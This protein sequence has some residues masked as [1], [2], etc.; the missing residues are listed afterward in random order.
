MKGQTLSIHQFHDSVAPGDAITQQLLF[1]QSSLKAVGITG[2]IFSRNI[3]GAL[4]EKVLPFRKENVWDCDVMLVHFSMGL[5]KPEEILKLEIPKALVYHNITPPEFFAHDSFLK[6]LAANG[7]KQLARHA[8]DFIANFSDS[9]FNRRELEKLGYRNGRLLPLFDLDRSVPDSS[10]RKA[11]PFHLLFVGRLAP[12]K[13]QALLIK[14]FYHL[15]SELP[16]DS[17]LYLVGTGDPI[18]THYLRLLIVQ[19]GLEEHVVLPGKVQPRELKRFY[20]TAGAFISASHH[21][22]F[23][24]PLVESMQAGL[25]VFYLPKAAVSE[26]MGKAGHRL[27][28]KEPLPLAREI[29]ATLG[30]SVQMAEI[31]RQQKTR[32]A[33]IAAFQNAKQV[34]NTLGDLLA[35]IR[36]ERGVELCPVP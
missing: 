29:A 23:G 10:A 12:H 20:E 32:L 13:N 6:S 4:E 18:Y 14:I 15:R 2:K 27:K 34:H 19:L 16:P 26:T 30:D 35:T 31:L 28:A 11:G 21:E 5:E 25:P 22:G 33:E 8:A 9:D 17:K 24:I 1:I 3:K 36:K 7:R